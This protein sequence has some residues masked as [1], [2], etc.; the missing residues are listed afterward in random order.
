MI[1]IIIYIIFISILCIFSWKRPGIVVG[2]SLCMFGLEQYVQS[3]NVFFV[4]YSSITN[5]L[6]G[7]IV[8]VAV[9]RQFVR[10]G[11]RR[12]SYGTSGLLII[13]FFIYVFTSA[14]WS[15]RP[16]LS[17]ERLLISGPYII[18][19]IVLAPL[20]I[21]SIKDLDDALKTT[22]YMGTSILLLLLFATEWSGRGV[23]V[24]GAKTK[25]GT[26]QFGNP[27]VPATL[28]GYTAICAFLSNY[29]S[30][31]KVWFV[32]R[33]TIAVLAIALAIKTGSRGQAISL[34]VVLIIFWSLRKNLS[35]KMLLP[36]SLI[37]A[38]LLFSFEFVIDLFWRDS[39]R[40][41]S[42]SMIDAASG[43]FYSAKVLIFKW[44]D[45][46]IIT[47]LFGLGNS[48][49]Y[50]P[51]ILGIYP[52]IVPIEVLGEEGLIGFA[53]FT[54]IM[55]GTIKHYI[56]LLRLTKESMNDRCITAI[57][58]GLFFYLFLISLKQ[59]SLIGSY[60]L[61][62][63]AILVNKYSLLTIEKMKIKHQK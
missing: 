43:R 21:R 13:Y 61:F 31:S 28:A 47:V 46:G 6:L 9:G 49:S 3:T 63:I 52:H 4:K 51:K 14:A 19:Y 40:W 50:D 5:I 23:V 59:G 54:V 53:I 10:Y 24:V 32:F 22:I 20:V 15:P 41:D 37:S 12:M 8:L 57:L 60:Q 34:T 2:T 56:K 11:T 33:F 39:G 35:L 38:M 18:T 30:R 55:L 26:A 17:F 48:A 58:G 27:L 42:D 16:D 1:E 62:L 7:L 45:G 44:F 36:L 29:W 25:Y